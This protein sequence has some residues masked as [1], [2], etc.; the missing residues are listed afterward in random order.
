MDDGS[1]YRCSSRK[2]RMAEPLPDATESQ[3][4][5]ATRVRWFINRDFGRACCNKQL[6]SP[7]LSD[8]QNGDDETTAPERQDDGIPRQSNGFDDQPLGLP[9]P[10]LPVLPQFSSQRQ[11]PP[12]S[13]A[14]PRPTESNA[15]HVSHPKKRSRA[16]SNRQTAKLLAHNLHTAHPSGSN[17]VFDDEEERGIVT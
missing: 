4:L 7:W 12:Q 3:H 9:P 8:E 15:T 11:I 6:V 17:P 14:H 16:Q 1:K 13:I 10:G 2:M 5:N